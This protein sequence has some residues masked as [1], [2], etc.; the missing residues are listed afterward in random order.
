M[1]GNEYATTITLWVQSGHTRNAHTERGV[2]GKQWDQV[3]A[4]QGGAAR[5]CRLGRSESGRSRPGRK[6][7]GLGADWGR[8][9]DPRP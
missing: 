7:P 9:S 3:P 4:K 6:A 2:G 5:V 8:P 1:E